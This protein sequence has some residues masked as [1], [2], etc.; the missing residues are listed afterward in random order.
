[1]VDNDEVMKSIDILMEHCEG[2][3]FGDLIHQIRIYHPAR[4]IGE[5]VIA[6]FSKD[7][8]LGLDY[9]H[10]NNIIHRDIK[11]GNILVT[12]SGVAKLCDFGVSGEI[13]SRL[14]ETF[15]GTNWYMSVSFLL[16]YFRF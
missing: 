6:R 4:L 12:K 16:I 8:L 7:V 15:I 11:P 2:G 14:A 3:S 1:M 5:K 13:E 10:T 9:L